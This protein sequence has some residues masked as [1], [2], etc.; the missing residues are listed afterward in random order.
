MQM[1]VEHGSNIKV[2]QTD[3]YLSGIVEELYVMK[4]VKLI[5]INSLKIGATAV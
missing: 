2:L 1:K 3:N 5:G 4:M